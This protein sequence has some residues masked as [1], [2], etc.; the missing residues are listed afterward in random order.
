MTFYRLLESI[1][2]SLIKISERSVF[3]DILL[4]LLGLL[5]TLIG[6]F[7]G[8]KISNI[9][10]KKKFEVNNHIEYLKH[11]NILNYKINKLLN[12][13]INIHKFSSNILNNNYNTLN[14]LPV[15][16]LFYVLLR[17]NTLRA[18]LNCN[19]SMFN[20]PNTNY[21]SQYNQ[22][23]KMISEVLEPNLLVDIF[24]EF[25]KEACNFYYLI[26]P[27]LRSEYKIIIKKIQYFSQNYAVGLDIEELKK[28]LTDHIIL[29][30][31]TITGKKI[32]KNKDIFDN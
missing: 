21:N 5:S 32:N 17:I 13:I 18:F 7:V 22:I 14:I 9:Q 6:I 28:T 31:E 12:N 16:D 10:D 23:M 26:K 8:Y 2:N 1:A 30:N 15:N 19:S 25:E 20:K 24:S 29:I 27:N 11:V 4:I 3:D